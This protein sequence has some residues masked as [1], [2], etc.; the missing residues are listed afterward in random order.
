MVDQL[1]IFVPL[2]GLIDINKELN[3]LDD[4]ITKMQGRLNA[5]NSKLN[6][7]SFVNKAPKMVVENEKT[8]QNKYQDSLNK[9][10][11][12]FNSLK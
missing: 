5:V 8:K 10:K 4:E 12:N 1:E 2:E 9:L 7:K 3:R 6:N 11:E